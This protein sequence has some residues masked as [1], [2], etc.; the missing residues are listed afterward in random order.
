MS[1]KYQFMSP[2]YGFSMIRFIF[3]KNNFLDVNQFN[4]YQW[5]PCEAEV[6]TF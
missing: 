4:Y 2:K 1:L 6:L 5:S 3:F